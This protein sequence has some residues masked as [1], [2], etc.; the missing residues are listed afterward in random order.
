MES[1]RIG[2]EVG[3]DYAIHVEE[4]THPDPQIIRTMLD[5]DLHTFAESTF[6]RFTA[7][8]ML[9]N[10][11]VYLLCAD[12]VTIGTCVCMRCWDRPNEAMILSMGIRPGWRG[13]GLGQRFVAGVLDKLRG[14]GL[15]SATLLV[16]Q[17]NRRAIKVY[18]DVGFEPVDETIGSLRGADVLMR[19]RVRLQDDDGPVIRLP[20]P[21]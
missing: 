13:R 18:R 3:R 2:G 6:S 4:V 21:G 9:A 5:I 8:A 20:D 12:E 1:F 19:M 14:R 17:E 15:R 11:R 16:G 7:A 10:G